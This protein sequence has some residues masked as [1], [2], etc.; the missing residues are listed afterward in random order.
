[1]SIRD[2]EGNEIPIR[3]WANLLLE[4]ANWL[5]NQGLLTTEKCPVILG[6]MNRRYLI[7]S[8]PTHPNGRSFTTK[9]HRLSNGLHIELHW[10]PKS[11][12]LRSFQLLSEFSQDPA[13]F[14]VLLG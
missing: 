14:C 8:I 9:N 6:G 13:E 12:A 1:M 7:H 4:T 11:M 2:P 3:N 10:G 5:A